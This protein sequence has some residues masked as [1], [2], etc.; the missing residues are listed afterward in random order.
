MVIFIEK[1]K[2]LVNGLRFGF[3]YGLRFRLN[4]FKH[5]VKRFGRFGLDTLILTHL[6]ALNFDFHEFLHFLKAVIYQIDKIQS[7]KKWQ[8]LQI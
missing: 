3:Y 5:S 8:K 4:R 6:E 1:L 7:P 2:Y